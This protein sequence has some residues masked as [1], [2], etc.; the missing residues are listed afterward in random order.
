M[1]AH[2]NRRDTDAKRFCGFFDAEFLNVAELK[3]L[4]INCGE[5]DNGILKHLTSLLPFQSFRRNFAPV[6]EQSR[7]RNFSVIGRVVE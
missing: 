6:A 4:A 3:D 1:K 2:F 5:A 7:R